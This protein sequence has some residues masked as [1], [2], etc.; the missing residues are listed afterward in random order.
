M[1]SRIESKNI[2][3][4]LRRI[5]VVKPSFTTCFFGKLLNSGKS[6]ARATE[7]RA[8][9]CVE[10]HVDKQHVR[11]LGTYATQQNHE[12]ERKRCLYI[13]HISNDSRRDKLS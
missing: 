8:H 2:V 10:S 12:Y 7:Q 11:T 13:Y 1:E 3:P 5:G 9:P 6:R 4:L